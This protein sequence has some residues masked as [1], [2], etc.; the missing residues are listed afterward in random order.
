MK[1]KECTKGHLVKY[2]TAKYCPICGTNSF[3]E[4]SSSKFKE[5]FKRNLDSDIISVFAVIF[6]FICPLIVLFIYSGTNPDTESYK[7]LESELRILQHSDRLEY[8]KRILN[9]DSLG[10]ATENDINS[11]L[12]FFHRDDRKD[13]LLLLKEEK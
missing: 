4:K 1:S 6:F 10:I 12:G 3:K 5:F 11:L 9:R 2:K 13:V 8:T 7:K